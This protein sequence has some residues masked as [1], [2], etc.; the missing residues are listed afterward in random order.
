MRQAEENAALEL[1]KAEKQIRDEIVSVSAALSEK[2]LEREVSPSDQTDLIDSLI[3]EMEESH[4][5][6]RS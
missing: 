4:E 3:R 1:K 6:H 2:I 5:A